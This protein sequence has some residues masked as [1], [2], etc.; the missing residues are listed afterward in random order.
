MAYTPVF[1]FEHHFPKIFKLSPL[2]VIVRHLAY[3]P[4][5]NVE[6][7]V[8]FSTIAAVSSTV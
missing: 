1:D 8:V 3:S 6:L 7:E 5:D 4:E 2:P